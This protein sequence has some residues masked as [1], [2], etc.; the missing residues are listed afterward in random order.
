M[1]EKFVVCFFET[2]DVRHMKTAQNQCN[3]TDPRI[4]T[5]SILASLTSVAYFS[6]IRCIPA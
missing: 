4:D 3:G 6:C 2:S 5:A 1:A